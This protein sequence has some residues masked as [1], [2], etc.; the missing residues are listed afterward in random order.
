MSELTESDANYVSIYGADFWKELCSEPEGFKDAFSLFLM[1]I[2]MT[3][4]MMVP[5][6]IPTLKT[7]QDLI[8]GGSGSS[9]GFILIMCGFS[10]VWIGYSLLASFA[11]ASLAELNLLK[12]D[13]TFIDPALSSILLFVAGLYQ[14]SSFKGACVSKCRAPMSFFLQYWG[15][16]LGSSLNMGLRLGLT[17]LG[18]CW[19]LMCLA[20]VGGTMNVAF[21]GLS[22]FVM[23]LE[24]LP[25]YGDYVTRPLG[26]ILI[27][28]A[29][30]N[31]L[32][33]Y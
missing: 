9:V 31:I 13:G 11:Q 7:Y 24:K 3:A 26:V 8:Y 4:A 5:T 6:L 23:V 20:L 15:P 17:C 25:R 29:S 28:G 14:F 22:T 30:L 27:I 16:G 21:M 18:C 12:G 19:V 32:T 33:A 1:W 2:I 10:V